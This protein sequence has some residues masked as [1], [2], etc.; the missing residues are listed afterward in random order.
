MVTAVC[1]WL[2]RFGTKDDVCRYMMEHYGDKE[3]SMNFSRSYEDMIKDACTSADVTAQRSVPFSVKAFVE[4][5][6]YK[7]FMEK[8]IAG[9]FDTDTDGAIAGGMAAGYFQEFP[10]DADEKRIPYRRNECADRPDFKI[11][12]GI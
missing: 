6:S 12:L 3:Y 1:V 8:I 5:T 4:S 2:V 10:F 11:L 9:G 7:D